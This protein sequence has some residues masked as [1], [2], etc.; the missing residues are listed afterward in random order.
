MVITAKQ[1]FTNLLN[2]RPILDISNLKVITEEII[3][4]K[5]NHLIEL[6]WKNNGN[7]PASL[8]SQKYGGSIQRQI[9]S[10]K[11]HW[12]PSSVFTVNFERNKFTNL[13]YFADDLN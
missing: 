3:A 8:L 6:S 7:L 1:P 9:P 4:Q 10:Q 12:R 5:Q 13:L 2:V 11:L